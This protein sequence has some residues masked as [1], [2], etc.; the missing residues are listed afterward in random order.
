MFW[1]FFW[2]EDFY[3][4]YCLAQ[5]CRAFIGRLRVSFPAEIV[6]KKFVVKKDKRT[7]G[8]PPSRPDQ[9][10]FDINKTSG[11]IYVLKV[12]G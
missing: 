3:D 2:A 6:L 1:Q 5:C 9:S 11:E 4:C 12:N 7:T 10:K 8:P